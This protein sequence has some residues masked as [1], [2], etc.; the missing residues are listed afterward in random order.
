[1]NTPYIPDKIKPYM[2]IYIYITPVRIAICCGKFAW[3]QLLWCFFLFPPQ[4][5][6]KTSCVFKILLLTQ[7]S[8]VVNGNT[9]RSFHEFS[10]S[11]SNQDKSDVLRRSI[12]T[13]TGCYDTRV[14]ARLWTTSK[15]MFVHTSISQS[16]MRD[17]LARVTPETVQNVLGS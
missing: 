11:T 1:M 13:A 15:A 7:L 16:L 2:Y 14:S 12:G 6:S 5:L 9:I 3:W 17:C 4:F 10:F 8:P